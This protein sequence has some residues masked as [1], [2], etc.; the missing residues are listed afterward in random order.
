MA[1]L[2]MAAEVFPGRVHAATVD[3]RL[4]PESADEAAMVAQICGARG[5]PHTTLT[6]EQPITGSLQARARVARYTLLNAWRGTHGID[7]VMT[8]HHADDQLET[9]VMR[10]NRSSGVGGLAGIR[11]IQGRVLRPLLDIRRAALAAWL[12]AQ[13]VDAIEDPSNRDDRFDR[14]R[15]RKALAAQTLLDPLAVAASAARLAAA[16]DALLWTTETLMRDHVT[17]ADGVAELV[18]RDIP[19]E[20]QRRLIRATLKALDH[21]YTEPRG[22]V[23]SRA[24]DAWR[25][26]EKAM[27]GDWL[28]EPVKQAPDILR[29]R[30]APPR[31]AG[32][33]SG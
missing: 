33:S 19:S 21:A 26:G 4:R 15:V 29:I 28:I 17:I 1:L 16:E 23:L 20:L 3:H 22:E 5:V 10:L 2:L 11:A 9:L 7:W 25:S 24:I 27:I 30:R 8:A 6:P 31:R 14:V 13:G 12:T 32:A 18:L